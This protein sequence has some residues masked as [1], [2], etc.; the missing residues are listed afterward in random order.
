MSHVRKALFD[1]SCLMLQYIYISRG[2]D[3]R[4]HVFGQLFGRLELLDIIMKLR[5]DQ[6]GRKERFSSA[7]YFNTPHN[8][9]ALRIFY[10]FSGSQINPFVLKTARSIFLNLFICTCT[11]LPQPFTIQASCTTAYFA[12]CSKQSCDYWLLHN[13]FA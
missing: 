1:Y 4:Q 12:F 10:Y 13:V 7:S 5:N 3:D 11:Q 2:L 8:T 6:R 9:L